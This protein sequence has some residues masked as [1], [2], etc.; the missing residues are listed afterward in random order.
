MLLDARQSG[1]WV[2]K[3]SPLLCHV[4]ALEG[5]TPASPQ[6]CHCLIFLLYEG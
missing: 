3:A 4:H 1:L 2:S 5:I 6:F